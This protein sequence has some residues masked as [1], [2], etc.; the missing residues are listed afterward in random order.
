MNRDRRNR[1]PKTQAMTDSDFAVG[2]DELLWVT[3]SGR[4]RNN[5]EN[6]QAV[7]WSLEELEKATQLLHDL[8]DTLVSLSSWR[9]HP[10]LAAPLLEALLFT[11]TQAGQRD[12]PE[13]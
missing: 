11:E 4:A 10:Q 13:L 8:V 9:E 1:P 3:P 12:I 5:V 6:F 2:V 7:G